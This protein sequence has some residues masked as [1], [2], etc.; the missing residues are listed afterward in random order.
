MSQ[1]GPTDSASYEAFVPRTFPGEV[2]KLASGGPASR[3]PTAP[4]PIATG[5]PGSA[6]SRYSLVPGLPRGRCACAQTTVARAIVAGGTLPRRRGE[7]SLGTLGGRCSSEARLGLLA[8]W[9]R[10]GF[11]DSQRF[12][13]GGSSALQRRLCPWSPMTRSCPVDPVCAWRGVPQPR[14]SRLT[15][16]ISG[17]G[18]RGQEEPVRAERVCQACC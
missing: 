10:C 3:M 5:G 13:S 8:S 7:V 6:T 15:Q 2:V 9:V 18:R 1:H 14:R 12:E 11:D 17:G 16:L 4:W